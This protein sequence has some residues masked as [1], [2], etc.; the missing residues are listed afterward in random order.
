MVQRPRESRSRQEEKPLLRGRTSNVEIIDRSSHASVSSRGPSPG[1]KSQHHGETRWLVATRHCRLIPPAPPLRHASR[2]PRCP[3]SSGSGRLHGRRTLLIRLPRPPA[4]LQQLQIEGIAWLTLPLSHQIGASIRFFLSSVARIALVA[5]A[6][7]EPRGAG[8]VLRAVVRALQAVGPHLGEGC[9]CA[10]G[11]RHG[12]S[13][14]CWCA[15]GARAGECA[16]SF[17]LLFPCNSSTGVRV[18]LNVQW[19]DIGSLAAI[20]S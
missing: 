3:P 8:W 18:D 9:R 12:R 14:R 6:E 10:Q 19:S 2:R 13:A 15:A 20:V 16:S 7:L 1:F 4:Q 11:R 5:G 17:T